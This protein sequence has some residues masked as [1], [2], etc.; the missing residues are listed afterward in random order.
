LT[1]S[2][3]LGT[4]KSVESSHWRAALYPDDGTISL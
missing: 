4:I 1:F 3:L 2:Y